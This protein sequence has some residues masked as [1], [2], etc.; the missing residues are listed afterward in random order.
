MGWDKKTIGEWSEAIVTTYKKTQD[1]Y[2]G[3]KKISTIVQSTHKGQ[4]IERF[5]YCGADK[6]LWAINVDGGLYFCHRHTNMP[7]LAI[8]N[9]SQATTSSI[10]MAIEQ[11]ALPPNCEQIPEVCHACVAIDYC[12]GGCWTD[13]LLMNGNS[14]TPNLIHCEM[15]KATALALGDFI[16][17]DTPQACWPIHVCCLGCM[18]CKEKY[19]CGECAYGDQPPGY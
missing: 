11:S 8:I 19:G 15:V 13:N 1:L 10:R 9:A 18:G 12:N 2:K 17:N 16:S 14:I 5:T 3:Q 4:D 7:E 6:D